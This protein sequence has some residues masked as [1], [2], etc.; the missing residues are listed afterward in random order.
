VTQQGINEE[1]YRHVADHRSAGSTGSTGS[2]GSA[3]SGTGFSEQ[4]HL[5]IEYAERFVLDHTNID[6]ELIGRMRAEFTDA[7]ILDLT[8]CLAHFLGTGRLF[9][10]LG[11]DETSQL[12][13]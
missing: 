9:R 6:D 11:I 7:E 10:V 12:E 8:I 3:G 5:A 4:E 2:A 13:V 1:F